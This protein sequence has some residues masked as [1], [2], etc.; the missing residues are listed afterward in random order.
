MFTQPFQLTCPLLHVPFWHHMQRNPKKQFRYQNLPCAQPATFF[1]PTCRIFSLLILALRDALLFPVAAISSSPGCCAYMHRYHCFTAAGLHSVLLRFSFYNYVR[2]YLN[3]SS[4]YISVM[5]P[6]CCYS[7]NVCKVWMAKFTIF[8]PAR[9]LK[10][11]PAQISRKWR[12]R[13]RKYSK[14]YWSNNVDI[15]GDAV[16]ERKSSASRD[17]IS[18]I[19]LGQC[20]TPE[21]APG[22]I[23]PVNEPVSISYIYALIHASDIARKGGRS[24]DPLHSITPHHR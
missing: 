2:R 21:C 13:R 1:D 3:I 17:M 14:K 4:L 20:W 19:P 7:T 12:I 9:M 8:R 10:L 23:E 6:M 15:S 24:I 18:R 22:S 11:Q 16:M 5:T